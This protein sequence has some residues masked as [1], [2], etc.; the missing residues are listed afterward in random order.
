MATARSVAII[1]GGI[2][3][4]TLANSLS[5]IGMSVSLY[6]RA[7]CF[8]PTSGAAFGLQPNGQISLESIGFQDQVKKIIQPFLKWQIIGDN[9]EL[10]AASDRLSEYGQRF[11]YFLG[12]AIRS[13]LVDILKEPI[14]KSDNLHY[15]HNL[16]NIKQDA[17]GVTL[18]FENEDQQKS[19]HADMVIGADGIRSTVVKQIFT[20]TA[21]PVHSKENIF[22][23]IIDNIDQQTSIN[24]L[25]TAKN[26]M[27]Q[28]FG[29][30]EFITYRA[31]HK[32]QLMWAVT[33]PSMAP[34]S[35]SEDFEWTEINNQRDLNQCLKRFPQSHPFHQC[36]AATDKTRLLHFGL[37][38]RQPRNDG[39]H[40][41]RICLLGDSCHATL[42]YVGQGAN[43]AIEDAISLAQ[44]LEKYKFQ[45]EPAFQEYHKK[46]FNRTKRVVNMARYMGLFLHSENP[47]VHSIRQRLVPWL[48]QSNMMIRMAEKELYENCPVPM[49]Q[50]KP[51]DK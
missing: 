29:F 12:G 16:I 38:Y 41:N 37:F 39:W 6:E 2:G 1:G 49:E 42:P 15:S 10:L 7:P 45:M 35:T 27:T 3:G 51:I 13:E 25:V 9:G 26:T 36:A 14:E 31:G 43:M 50:R 46:R 33:Y 23:G 8:I 32:G 11:G 5:Q 24:P 21:A 19:V 28:Y 4:L 22:Y 17:N 34:P 20:E 30:G 44:C 48:M 40:R 47:L 18:L